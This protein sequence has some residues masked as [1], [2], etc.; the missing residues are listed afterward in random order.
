M[1]KNIEDI[2]QLGTIMGIWAHPDDETWSSAGIMATAI[3]QGQHVA[4]LSATN[5]D[6][7]RTADETRWAQVS[8]RDIR[9]TELR[10]AL[11]AVGVSD[12]SFLDYQDD[13]LD[14]VDEEEILHIIERHVRAVQPDTIL[15]FE[16]SGITGHPDHKKISQWAQTVAKRIDANITVYGAVTTRDNYEHIGKKADEELNVFF[17]IDKPNLYDE[18]DLAIAYCLP[19]D[20]Q[21][22]KHAAFEAH[23]SQT[24]ALMNHPIGKQLID[25][26]VEKEAFIRLK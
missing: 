9:Q 19:K 7:G 21:V 20:I 25:Q 12:I 1:I 13:K 17:A 10:N 14:T 8:L 18:K 15:T 16:P 22:K 2:K 24:H 5:G 11:A 23:A 6:A 4:V 3:A 26:A